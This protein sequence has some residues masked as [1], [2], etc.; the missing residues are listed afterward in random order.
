MSVP[1]ALALLWT[2]GGRDPRLCSTQA[3]VDSSL[4]EYPRSALN[5]LLADD[6]HGRLQPIRRRYASSFSIGAPD[7]RSMV[8]S[9]ACRCERTPLRL[10]AIDELTGQP[11]W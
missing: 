7:T 3:R 5:G 8:T 11:A 1:L 9:R 2:I 4:L 6:A 10:S